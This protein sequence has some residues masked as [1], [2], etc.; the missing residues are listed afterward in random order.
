MLVVVNH[1]N[2]MM[3]KAK[4]VDFAICEKTV[5]TGD[6]EQMSYESLEDDNTMFGMFIVNGLGVVVLS[7]LMSEDIIH[8]HDVLLLS[9][10]AKAR[11]YA[12][13]V[14]LCSNKQYHVRYAAKHL[15]I[16]MQRYYQNMRR[17]NIILWLAAKQTTAK[18]FYSKL[19]F[20]EHP[21]SPNVMFTNHTIS[22][23]SSSNSQSS[24][25]SGGRKKQRIPR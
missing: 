23:S 9:I 2:Y 11:R 22:S 1:T 24:P 8:K 4:I 12:E 14:L 3:Y 10:N 15:L 21:I 16:A 6:F 17:R 18:D 5:F 25:P 19:G 20:I 13:L 7:L